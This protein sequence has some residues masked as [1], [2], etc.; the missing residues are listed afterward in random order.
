MLEISL[1]CRVPGK[2]KRRKTCSVSFFERSQHII[3]GRGSRAKQLSHEARKQQR[4]CLHYLTF[5]SPPSP[6]SIGWCHTDAETVFYNQQILPGISLTDTSRA[7]LGNFLVTFNPVKNNPLFLN[8]MSKYILIYILILSPKSYGYLIMKNALGG[9]NS[10]C[11]PNSSNVV[12]RVQ[13]N[14][15]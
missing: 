14:V 9:S 3:R 10:L 12:A 5:P 8:L 1:S 15:F 6:G 11:R 7:Y 13:V 2:H 4:Q